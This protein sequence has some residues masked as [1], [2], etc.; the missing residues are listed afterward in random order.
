MLL[1][2]K[3]NALAALE[4]EMLVKA[5]QMAFERRIGSLYLVIFGKPQ[6]SRWYR[7]LAVAIGD[8]CVSSDSEFTVFYVCSVFGEDQ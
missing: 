4:Q 7:A 5:T 8:G 2:S 3:S 1:Q 6:A